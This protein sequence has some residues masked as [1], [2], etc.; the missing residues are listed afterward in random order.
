MMADKILTP[1]QFPGQIHYDKN[2][3][4]QQAIN[5]TM[6]KYGLWIVRSMV[7]VFCQTAAK[8]TPPNMGKSYIDEKYYY[9][10]VQ[11]LAKL[12]K[13]EYK[14]YHATVADYAALR[15]GFKFRVLNTKVGHK[16]NEVFAYTRGINQAKAISRIEN[17]GLARYTWGNAL[18]NKGV[19][20]A[21]RN[22][23]VDKAS[24]EIEL[25]P[26][27]KRLERKSPNI[28]KFNF[29]SRELG[30]RNGVIT[31]KVLNR[32]SQSERY[33]QI[34]VS[35]AR[36]EVNKW[37]TKFFNKVKNKMEADVVKMIQNTKMSYVTYNTT[38]K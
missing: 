2:L 1:V 22:L 19:Y 8:F 16:R 12:A 38:Q 29:G 20:W 25:P 21:E 5:D 30:Y 3:S 31:M 7:R 13:G 23:V 24:I 4:Q 9:R 28:T 18:N 36:A 27:F 32:L 17:R 15:A 37:T 34:A 6:K 14:P 26:I 33:C 11:D 35:K 10:P